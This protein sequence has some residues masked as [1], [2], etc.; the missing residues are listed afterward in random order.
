M[1]HRGGVSHRGDGVSDGGDGQGGVAVDGDVGSGDSEA[2]SVADVVPA[3]DQAVG[4]DVGEASLGDTSDARLDLAGGTAGVAE[5][6][7]AQLVLRVVLGAGAVAGQG[8]QLRA[9]HRSRRE[10]H[11]LH[12]ETN[13]MLDIFT[14]VL[15]TRCNCS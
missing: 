13:N 11:N 1:S 15:P 9:A 7:L 14:S 5:G 2:V 8:Q 3:L 12:T 6:V 4:V 10:Q